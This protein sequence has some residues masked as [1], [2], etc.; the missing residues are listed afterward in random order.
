MNYADWPEFVR[1]KYWLTRLHIGDGESTGLSRS[2]T[3]ETAIKWFYDV[4]TTLDTKAS[5]LMR[6]NGVLIAAAAFLLGVV[7]R[8]GTTILSTEPWDSRL[9]I[10][11]ALLS[12]FSI[13]L[14]LFVVDVSWPFLGKTI[15][16]GD[17]CN[18]TDEIVSLDKVCNFR[19]RMYRLAWLISLIA[20]LGFLLEFGRQT[21]NVF[22]VT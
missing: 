5:A 7:G 6:L 14:C 10:L 22:R 20:S 13:T 21:W 12:A 18:A 1:K 16:V 15:V 8:S 3:A 2:V 19:R 4:L 9:I 11:C 17:D